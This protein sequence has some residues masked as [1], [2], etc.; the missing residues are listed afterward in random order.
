MGLAAYECVAAG[1]FTTAGATSY[2]RGGVTIARTG[3][4]VYTL[5]LSDQLQLDADEGQILITP[6]TANIIAQ[7]VHTSD[8][9]KTV[10]TF[11]GSTG[12]ATDAACQFSIWKFAHGLA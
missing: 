6:E 10:N 12:A 7:V 3:A 1:R 4:G 8:T 9:V 5:T 11:L 2:V